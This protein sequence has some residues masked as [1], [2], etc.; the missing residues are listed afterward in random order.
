M[1]SYAAFLAG[2]VVSLASSFLSVG[3]VGSVGTVAQR[4]IGAFTNSIDSGL[5]L[6]SLHTKYK[7]F[8]VH[9]D[10]HRLRIEH[11]KFQGEQFEQRSS[12]HLVDCQVE[13]LK[14]LA[15]NSM[16]MSGFAIACFVELPIPE[17][18]DSSGLGFL[19]L[20]LFAVAVGITVVL[21]TTCRYVIEGFN[22]FYNIFNINFNFFVVYAIVLSRPC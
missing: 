2:E 22:L 4:G 17:N 14:L 3:T 1:L 20:V 10:W 8:D 5:G 18:V 6:L 13:Q 15:E 11:F 19:V 12:R 9:S 21:F 16:W 7:H